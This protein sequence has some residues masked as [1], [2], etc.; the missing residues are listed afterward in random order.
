[1]EESAQHLAYAHSL[2]VVCLLFTLFLTS[3]WQD[4][5]NQVVLRAV[6]DDTVSNIEKKEAEVTEIKLP[7]SLGVFKTL[8]SGSQCPPPF[9]SHSYWL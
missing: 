1:M 5:N 6:E 8:L 4:K 2:S 3:H 9:L 7:V